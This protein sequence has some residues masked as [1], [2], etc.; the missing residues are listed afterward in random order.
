MQGTRDFSGLDFTGI[1]DRE[2]CRAEILATLPMVAFIMKVLCSSSC[3]VKVLSWAPTRKQPHVNS[4][5]L[6]VSTISHRCLS[7]LIKLGLAGCLSTGL[8]CRI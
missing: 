2:S 7:A 4:P 6:F 8:S 5:Y 3:A 1:S